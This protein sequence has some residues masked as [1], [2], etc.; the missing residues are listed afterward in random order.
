MG[1]LLKTKIK[2]QFDRTVTERSKGF[3]NPVSPLKSPSIFPPFAIAKFTTRL[4]G[5]AAWP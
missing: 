4:I 1:C 2:P 3:F 5:S